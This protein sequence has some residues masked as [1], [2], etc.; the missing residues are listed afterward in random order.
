MAVESDLLEVSDRDAIRYAGLHRVGVGRE[1]AFRTPQI[2]R[3]AVDLQIRVLASQRAVRVRLEAV[4][5]VIRERAGVD[6]VVRDGCRLLLPP[7]QT[8]LPTL[9]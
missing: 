6:A 7:S 2:R 8:L 5:V 1:S 4:A 3:E 9:P